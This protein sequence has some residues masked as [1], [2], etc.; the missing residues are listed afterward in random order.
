MITSE[1]FRTY[2]KHDTLGTLAVY[3][4]S[5][6]I[7]SCKTLELPWKDNAR[8]ISCIPEG[9][10]TVVKRNTAKRGDHWHVLNVPGRTWILFHPANY[11]TQILGCIIPGQS[12]VDINGDGLLD[13][14]QSKMTLKQM[15]EAICEDS[16][17]LNIRS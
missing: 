14:N 5:Q 7:F 12:H 10:Y 2:G 4:D 8:N 15:N 11:V 16:F 1:L 6:G 9:T 17:I 13:V 3:D